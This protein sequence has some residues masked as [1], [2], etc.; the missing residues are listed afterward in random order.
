MSNEH[1]NI[2]SAWPNGSWNAVYGTWS[3]SVWLS[4][5]SSFSLNVRLYG[6]NE[7]FNVFIFRLE[8]IQ[9]D[10]H[11][12]NYSQ[13]TC[14]LTNKFVVWFNSTSRTVCSCFLNGD[15]AV[16][17]F[18]LW[19]LSADVASYVFNKP[20]FCFF[21]GLQHHSTISFCSYIIKTVYVFWNFMYSWDLWTQFKLLF[22]RLYVYPDRISWIQTLVI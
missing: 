13:N 22:L 8:F 17:L 4:W 18:A 11:C 6:V 12:I 7:F 20:I 9:I 16:L 10:D 14:P 5:S 19:Y 15:C 1:L 21:L 3:T 2:P